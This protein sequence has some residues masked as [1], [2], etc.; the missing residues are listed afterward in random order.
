MGSNS[1][2]AGGSDAG[3]ENTKKSKVSTLTKVKIAAK[4]IKPPIVAILEGVGE[5][6]KKSN[7]KRRKAFIKKQGLTGDDINM[8]DDYLSSKEGLAELKK[9]GYTTVSD[10][11]P[12]GNDNDRGGN[13]VVQAPTDATMTAPT[14]A[15]VSQSSA[16]DATDAATVDTDDPTYIK[17]KTKRQGRSLTILTSSKGAS[18]G[19]TLGKRSLL[20]S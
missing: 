6:A 16:T 2:S 12:S 4:K 7:L 9:Q 5:A 19:L 13:Q 17:R 18:D 1:A 15:E 11:T 10:L 8:S 20:G 14:T 3:F